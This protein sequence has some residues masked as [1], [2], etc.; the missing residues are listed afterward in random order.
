V[1]AQVA[2]VLGVVAALVALELAR[3]YQL[4]RGHLIQLRLALGELELHHR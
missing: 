3:A 1:V 2:I 4:L